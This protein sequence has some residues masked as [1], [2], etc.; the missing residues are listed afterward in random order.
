MPHCLSQHIALVS[1]V[2]ARGSVGL[3]SDSLCFNLPPP[4]YF[5][6]LISRMRADPLSSP[7]AHPVQKP[8]ANATSPYTHTLKPLRAFLFRWPHRHD[9]LCFMSFSTSHVLADLDFFSNLYTCC[10]YLQPDYCTH[11][12]THTHF[13]SCLRTQIQSFIKWHCFSLNH[14]QSL[15]LSSH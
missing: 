6:S 2:I 1:D 15:I 8:Q 12:Q 13:E 9:T 4:L 7:H 10:Q 11:A 3:S 5:I 14:V